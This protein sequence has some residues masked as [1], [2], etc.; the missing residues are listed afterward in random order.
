MKTFIFFLI[1]TTLLSSLYA[2]AEGCDNAKLIVQ[3][4][5]ILPKGD[6][7]VNKYKDS[8]LWFTQES[9]RQEPDKVNWDTIVT[10]E[11]AKGVLIEILIQGHVREFAVETKWQ[12]KHTLQINVEWGHVLFCSYDVD[13]EKKT[14]S[15]VKK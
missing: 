1:F 6:L 15:L 2:R 3:N 7:K 13:I 10:A 4:T 5:K 11:N 8:K 12:D 9:H 14:S